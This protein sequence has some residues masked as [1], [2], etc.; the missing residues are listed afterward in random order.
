MSAER[1]ER[2]RE[3]LRPLEAHERPAPLLVASAVAAIVAIA[4]IVGVLVSKN[5]AR[6]GGSAPGGGF[7]AA[8]LLVLAANMYRRRYWAV[9]G[10]EALL[11]FQVV[12]TTLALV[13]A[14]SLLSAALCVVA[15]G[16]GGLLFWKLVRVMSRLQAPGRPD[17]PADG[18]R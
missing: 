3:R 13:V 10:F 9:L 16:L 2:L 5:L 12:L 8:V 11:A 6:D 15:I 14:Q 4:V 17:E 7:I 18:R 1:E